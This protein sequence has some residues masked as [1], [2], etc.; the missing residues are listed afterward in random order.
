MSI[1]AYKVGTGLTV[2]KRTKVKFSNTPRSDELKEMRQVL[3]Q[4]YTFDGAVTEVE[5]YAISVIKM[6]ETKEDGR[7][8]LREVQ[9]PEWYACQIVER[10]A[11]I[12]AVK[13]RVASGKNEEADALARLSLYFGHLI[14][15]AT[16]KAKWEGPALTALKQPE[17]GL[18]G[19]E[20]VHGNPDEKRRRRETY[21]TSFDLARKRGLGKMAAYRAA[22]KEHKKHVKTI[23]RA[24][25]ES[26]T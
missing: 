26:E 25:K 11:L 9:S 5:D 2:R 17:Y 6:A 19:H 3:D 15:E 20:K 18:L 7:N 21:R 24:V 1:S 4:D 22:A 14:F 16:F 12:R 23:Q 10:L 8:R 13:Q